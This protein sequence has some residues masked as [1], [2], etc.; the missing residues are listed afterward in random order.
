MTELADVA[1]AL[2]EDLARPCQGTDPATLG[3]WLSERQRTLD[4][5]QGIDARALSDD[6]RRR[7]A[8]ALERALRADA[9]RAEG[10]ARAAEECTRSLAIAERSHRVTENPPTPSA[11]PRPRV[12][13]RA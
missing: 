2:A 4:R 12:D 1:L 3:A 5:L 9:G 10:W 13:R 11:P 7:L 8:A 6:V